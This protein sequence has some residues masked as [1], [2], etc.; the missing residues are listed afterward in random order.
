M[1]NF[2]KLSRA[3][4]KKVTGGNITP[5]CE[6]SCT[7]VTD[8]HTLKTFTYVTPVPDC[9]ELGTG[10]CFGGTINWCYCEGGGP[11]A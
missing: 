2:S 8:P 1:S 3:E 11:Q 9:T 5:N 6:M 10:S 7:T 4:M